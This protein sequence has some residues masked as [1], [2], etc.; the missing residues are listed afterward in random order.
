MTLEHFRNQ[1]QQRAS[2][3]PGEPNSLD[4]REGARKGVR[5]YVTTEPSQ[6]N[7]IQLQK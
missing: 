6:L 5:I 7:Q 1:W 4:E 2:A 3:R